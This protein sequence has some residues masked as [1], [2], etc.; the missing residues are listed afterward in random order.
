MTVVSITGRRRWAP[1][2]RIASSGSALRPCQAVE[3][4][5]QHDVVVH[6]DAGERDDAD[7]RHDDAERLAGDQQAEHHADVDMTTA[8]RIR[9]AL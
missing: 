5:D 2:R 6:H 7:A 9:K 1:V 3:G 4:V 8:D